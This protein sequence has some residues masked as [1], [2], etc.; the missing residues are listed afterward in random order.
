MAA[1]MGRDVSKLKNKG[2]KWKY[3]PLPRLALS[4]CCL[5][6]TH[7]DLGYFSR[8]SLPVAYSVL[9]G[10]LPL[11]SASFSHAV[12]PADD[13]NGRLMLTLGLQVHDGARDAVHSEQLFAIQVR[14]SPQCRVQLR[15]QGSTCSVLFHG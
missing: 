9:D 10:E 1:Y 8:R 6:I 13:V 12:I 5:C 3:V 15:L 14:G 7:T 11:H 4:Y 2:G